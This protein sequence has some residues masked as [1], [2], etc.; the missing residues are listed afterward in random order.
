MRQR[1]ITTTSLCTLVLFG[2]LLAAPVAAHA[3]VYYWEE[4]CFNLVEHCWATDFTPN[5]GSYGG[6]MRNDEVNSLPTF[7]G[8]GLWYG[9]AA[10]NPSTNSPFPPTGGDYP[11]GGGDSPSEQWCQQHPYPPGVSC[12]WSA[13]QFTT[14]D[15]TDSEGVWHFAMGGTNQCESTVDKEAH[16]EMPCGVGHRLYPYDC[17][18]AYS[19]RCTYTV[20]ND[21]PW[22]W[23]F[24][25]STMQFRM[26]AN[27]YVGGK[28]GP[29]H[30]Y[31]CAVVVDQNTAATLQICDE[32]WN[33]TGS[34]EWTHLACSGSQFVTLWQP[35]GTSSPYMYSGYEADTNR[36]GS[37]IHARWQ[38]NRQQLFNLI[39]KAH[40]P[41]NAGGCAMPADYAADSWKLYYSENGIE[42]IGPS[43]YGSGVYWET[44]GETMAT[45][46]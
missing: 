40:E 21:D 39:A 22:D 44:S 2:L 45:W 10:L 17:L 42:K 27:V 43:G 8:N 33:S 13:S 9:N 31:L 14:A 11:W 36:L 35:G 15:F 12:N 16:S 37:W 1:K 3:G 38:M 32:P 46:Y 30:D 7:D 25:E 6:Q 26:A 28:T 23:G 34:Y 24:P 4:G 18:G 20:P 29:W 41:E 19:S 5:S